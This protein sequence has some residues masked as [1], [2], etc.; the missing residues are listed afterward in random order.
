MNLFV[1]KTF[2]LPTYNLATS[3][4]FFFGASSSARKGW[5]YVTFM[6]L[7]MIGALMDFLYSH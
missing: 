6:I 7:P 3:S 4:D 5:W 2:S 1:G